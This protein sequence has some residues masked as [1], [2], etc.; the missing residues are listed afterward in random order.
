AVAGKIIGLVVDEVVEVGTYGRQQIFP[1]P[2]FLKGSGSEFF[3]GV[4]H[5]Q[6]E[7][8]LILNLEKI[9]SSKEKIDLDLIQQP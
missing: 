6:D 3:L 4:C 1:A 9:L 2:R 8:V 5:W 7:L